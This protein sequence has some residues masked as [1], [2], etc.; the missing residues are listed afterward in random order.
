[1]NRVCMQ[2]MRQLNPTPKRLLFFFPLCGEGGGWIQ[3]NSGV[4]IMLPPCPHIFPRFP[5]CSSR[6]LQMTPHFI[7][8]PL[9]KLV[10]PF[11]PI[12]RCEPKRSDYSIEPAISGS[13]LI[14]C[15]F[16]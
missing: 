13:L 5:M 4:S 12:Y 10:F 7:P 6:I 9:P 1:M 14:S 8:Y 16:V 3:R 11:S 15:I 2:A